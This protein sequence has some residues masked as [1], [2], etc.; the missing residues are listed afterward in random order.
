MLA[1]LAILLMY[2][3]T[4]FIRRF[5][6]FCFVLVWVVIVVV[7]VVFCFCFSFRVSCPFLSLADNSTDEPYNLLL[8]RV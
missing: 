2:K 7:V 8:S 1:R 6:L 4:A 3:D 5:R